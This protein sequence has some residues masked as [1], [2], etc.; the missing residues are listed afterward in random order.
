MK[1]QR[2]AADRL[3]LSV[4]ISTYFRRAIIT[5][6]AELVKIPQLILRKKNIQIS[7]VGGSG[8]S[9]ALAFEVTL[10]KRVAWREDKGDEGK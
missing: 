10:L 2:A 3:G 8:H 6:R 7:G 4:F 1:L 5:L 9:N